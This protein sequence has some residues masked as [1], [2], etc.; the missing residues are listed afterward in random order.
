MMSLLNNWDASDNNNSIYVVDGQQLYLVSDVGA[1]LGKTGNSL[2]RS[3]SDLK[4]YQESTFI[5]TKTPTDVDFELH[6]RPFFLTVFDVSNYHMRTKIEDVTKQIPRADA[7]WL[8]QLL[9]QLSEEQIRD[10]FRT[11]GYTPQEVDGYT[12][13]VRKRIA[14]LNAL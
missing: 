1:T 12:R 7:R 11:A 14:E 8:G 13:T 2:S 6:S 10:C 9:G 3:K 5:K 4:G